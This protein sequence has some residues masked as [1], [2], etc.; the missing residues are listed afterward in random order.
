MKYYGTDP[1]AY[2]PFNFGLITK[3]NDGSNASDFNDAVYTWLE[4]LPRGK[5]PNWVVKRFVKNQSKPTH[6]TDRPHVD[7]RSEIMTITVW[8]LEWVPR[9]LTR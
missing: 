2:L 9:W 8:P 6:I 4:N 5:W 3:L 1:G 7:F